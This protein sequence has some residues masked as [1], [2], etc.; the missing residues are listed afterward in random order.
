MTNRI[1]LVCIIMATCLTG[2]EAPKGT[3]SDNQYPATGNTASQLARARVALQKRLTD[4]RTVQTDRDYLLNRLRLTILGLADGYPQVVGRPADELFEML[5]THGINEAKEFEATVFHEELRI[6]KG[7]PFEQAM[8]FHYIATHYAILGSWDNVRA[9]SLNS[10][11]QLRDYSHESETGTI[12]ADA[13]ADRA[14]AIENGQAITPATATNANGYVTV[15]ND[16]T[17]GYLLCAIANEQLARTLGDRDRANEARGLFDQV[18]KLRPSLAPLIAAFK[19]E[20]F[21]TLLIVDA[22]Q[23]PRKARTGP[24]GALTIYNPIDRS[25]APLI[26]RSGNSEQTFDLV[27]DLNRLATS[28]LWRGR[29]GA[30]LAKSTVGTGMMMGGS[31]AASSRDPATQWAGLGLILGG[32]YA[33]ATAGADTRYC[34]LLPQRVYLVPANA[35]APAPGSFPGSAPGNP[36][37]RGISGATSGASGASGGGWIQLQVKGQLGTRLTLTGLT[38]PQSGKVQ[39]RYVRL[40]DGTDP[41]PWAISGKIHYAGDGT[42]ALAKPSLPY[43]L[44]GRSVHQPTWEQV[45]RWREAGLPTELDTNAVVDLFKQEKIELGDGNPIGIHLLEGGRTLTSPLP[46]SLGFVRLFCQ[47]HPIYQP[48]SQAVQRLWP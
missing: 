5:T 45:G 11:S 35:P 28:H 26:V 37:N 22:G 23:G 24:D 41:P 48:R 46:G 6:W 2:C 25:R 36:K 43:I 44:G 20:Q 17:L 21:N 16:F 7:E 4:S 18:L 38:A 15:E 9:A 30:R 1:A 12:N 3:S 13:L 39:V 32:L 33:K 31:V 10:L 42:P 29:E 19:R 8:A 34:E 14:K 47:E 40:L 27:S